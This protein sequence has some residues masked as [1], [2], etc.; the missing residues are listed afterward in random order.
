MNWTGSTEELGPGGKIA[1][2]DFETTGLCPIRGRIVE[3]GVICFDGSEIVDSYRSYVD[4]EGVKVTA[5]AFKVNGITRDMLRGAPRFDEGPMQA[6]ERLTEGRLVV[7][8]RL[9]FDL[10]FWVE[11][12]KRAGTITPDRSVMCSKLLSAL[13][14]YYGSLMQIAMS[15]NLGALRDKKMHQALDDC[16]VSALVAKRAVWRLGGAAAAWRECRAMVS[17]NQRMD[18]FSREDMAEISAYRQCI[19]PLPAVSVASAA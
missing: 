14:G 6:I 19:P 18:R 4:P 1:G 2:L 17:D 10:S 11:S 7:A 13:N 12:C 5:G 3:V 15:F 9:P 8:H 16:H